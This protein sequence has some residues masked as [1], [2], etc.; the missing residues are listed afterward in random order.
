[1]K[2]GVLKE[3]KQGERRVALSPD[4]IKQ[5]IKKEFSVT[6]EQDAGIGSNFSD[7]D[8]KDAGATVGSSQDVFNADLLL[9]VNLFRSKKSPK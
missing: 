2:I 4:V 8:Y 6:V 3:T 9:K 7:Q 5:L 1:M